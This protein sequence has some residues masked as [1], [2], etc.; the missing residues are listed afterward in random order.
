[1]ALF[2]NE[3]VVGVALFIAGAA[4]IG[5]C[6]YEACHQPDDQLLWSFVFFPAAFVQTA[7][8][9]FVLPMVEVWC[10]SL[11]RRSSSALCR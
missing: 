1:M 8:V 4:P 5:L 3:V 10:C 2:L 9:V 6:L 7:I 11:T